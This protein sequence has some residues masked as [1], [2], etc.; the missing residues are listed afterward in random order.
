MADPGAVG[1]EVTRRPT[2]TVAPASTSV[3]GAYIADAQSVGAARASVAAWLRT[4]GADEL[5]TGDVELAISEACTNA[6]IHAHRNGDRGSFRV[7]AESE[8]HSVRVTVTDDG[9]GMA[10]RPDSPGLGLGLPLIAALTDSLEVRPAFG[11]SGTVV[12]MLFSV[13]GAQARTA[14]P[15]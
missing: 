8:G 14:I 1:R 12:S 7:V 4:L 2:V 13:A 9:C 10:P 15:H 11:V 5:M 6:V 3:D